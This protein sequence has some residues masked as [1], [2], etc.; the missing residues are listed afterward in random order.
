MTGRPPPPDPAV[1]AARNRRVM[2][3]CLSIV[4]GMVGLSFAAVPLYD[5]F[6]KVTGFGGTP[7]MAATAPSA[8]KVLERTITV[9]FNADVNHDLPWKFAPAAVSETVKLGEARETH[10]KARNL[11]GQAIVGTATYNVTPEKAGIYFNKVQCFCFTRQVLEPGQEVEMPVTYFV[12]PAIAD[13]PRMADVHTITLSYT[14]FKATD[15]NLDGARQK[16]YQESAQAPAA[17]AAT[18]GRLD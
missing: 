7:Q 17:P 11:S 16:D 10:Y 1:T 15:Q 14:F 13:D 3:V 12:D 4:A 6:C 9:R 18:P 8:D 5:L 2:L